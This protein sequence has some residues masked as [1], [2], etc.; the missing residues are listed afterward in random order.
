MTALDPPSALGEPVGSAV[1]REQPEDFRVE[2]RMGVAPVGAGEH[3]WVEVRKVGWNTEDVAHWLARVAGV[4]RRAVSFSGLKDR[5]AVTR[6]WFSLHLPGRPDPHLDNPPEGIVILDCRRH[7]RKLNRGTHAGNS[8]ELKLRH[9]QGHE[10]ALNQRLG[11]IRQ[12]GVPNYFGAQRFG[13]GGDNAERA[14]A[15]LEGRGEAPRK[16]AIRGIWLSALRAEL[17]NRVLAE[18]VRQGCWDS[19]LEGDVLQPD[20]SRGLF[21]EPDEPHA[22]ERVAAGRVHPTAPLPGAGGMA[23]SG[24]CAALEERI[25]AADQSITQRLSD[26]G[27]EAARRATRLPVTGLTLEF[28]QDGPRL[29][30]ALPAG[31]YATTVLTE[32]IR[33][34]MSNQGGDGP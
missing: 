31:A 32:L 22:A 17:F 6:Q 9:W 28:E 23:P 33:I 14:R 21:H 3:L 4:A 20:G 15:W 29:W 19:V 10:E 5:Q 27:V 34:R 26:Q 13:R 25:L 11:V 16:R 30:F 12:R 8:F 1:L 2:E 18:R 7:E 24:A